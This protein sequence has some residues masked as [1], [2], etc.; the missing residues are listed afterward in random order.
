MKSEME[1][2]AIIAS[3]IASANRRPCLTDK[4]KVKGLN[5]VYMHVEYEQGR[6][7]K[8]RLSSPGKYSDAAIG[9]LLDAIAEKVTEALR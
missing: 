3:R 8:L 7:V 4:I 9:T 5:A 6:A 2:A 1:R